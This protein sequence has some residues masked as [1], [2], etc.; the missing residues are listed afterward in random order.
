VPVALADDIHLARIIL[1]ITPWRLI[2]VDDLKTPCVQELSELLLNSP[3]LVPQ[4]WTSGTGQPKLV[5]RSI[6]GVVK[7]PKPGYLARYSPNRR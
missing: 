7:S 2:V 3:R 5:D 4:P 6:G 1:A